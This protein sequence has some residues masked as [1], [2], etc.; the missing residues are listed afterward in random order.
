[1]KVLN[2]SKR[3]KG[4]GEKVSRA[5]DNYDDEEQTPVANIRLDAEDEDGSDTAMPIKSLIPPPLKWR[6]AD[7]NPSITREGSSNSSKRSKRSKR[8]RSEGDSETDVDVEGEGCG[9]G[10]LQQ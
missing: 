10:Q 1:M 6:K 5:N 7:S 4:S 2:T 9:E 8:S 3:K